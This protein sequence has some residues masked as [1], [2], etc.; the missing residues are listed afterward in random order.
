MSLGQSKTQFH[1]MAMFV[2][3]FRSFLTNGSPFFSRFHGPHQARLNLPVSKTGIGAWCVGRRPLSNQY[4]QVDFLKKTL[5]TG[6]A[7]Q[8]NNCLTSELA[9]T[10]TENLLKI[11]QNDVWK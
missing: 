10:L 11:Q 7:T 3:I 4:L 9:V 2:M 5:I 1:R 8:G 6:V